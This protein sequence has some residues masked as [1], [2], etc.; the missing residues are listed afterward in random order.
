MHTGTLKGTTYHGIEV[1][2]VTTIDE[3]MQCFSVRSAAFIGR[4]SEPYAEEFD[5]NDVSGAAHLLALDGGVPV[6]TMRVRILASGDGGVA[7]WQ[8]FASVPSGKVGMKVLRALAEAAAD[9]TRFKQ[10][11]RVVG[12]VADERLIRFWERFG[13]RRTD[14]PPAVYNGVPYQ[15]IEVRF[16]RIGSTADEACGR[17]ADSF[18]AWR[19]KAALHLPER[20]GQSTTAET[21]R[22][23]ERV[24]A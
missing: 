1:R 11:D 5:G 6:G 18:Y 23:T 21:A 9:Y 15:R 16:S 8:R 22:P 3:L 19:E 7:T 14:D 13:F 12:E 4:E 17:E 10:V 2:L 20:A 24:A